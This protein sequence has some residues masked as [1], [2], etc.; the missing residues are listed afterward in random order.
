M[1]EGKVKPGEYFILK[2]DFSTVER[3]QDINDAARY[4]KEAISG[5]FEVFYETYVTYLGEDAINLISP[6]SPARSLKRCVRR[7]NSVIRKLTDIKGVRM[8]CS[9]A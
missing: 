6:D 7:V 1:T 3:S 8:D 2:F 5:A 4:L 9:L